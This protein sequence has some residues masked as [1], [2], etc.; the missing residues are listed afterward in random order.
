VSKVEIGDRQPHLGGER[1]LTDEIAALGPTIPQPMI[2]SLF[3][4]HSSH[5]QGKWSADW[6]QAL[7]KTWT[8]HIRAKKPSDRNRGADID[9][10][11]FPPF[12]S[13]WACAPK[14]FIRSPETTGQLSQ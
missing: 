3:W 2:W 13:R 10:F 9:F 1:G 14:T 7:S 11:L 12:W 5:R 6:R 4:I 8:F